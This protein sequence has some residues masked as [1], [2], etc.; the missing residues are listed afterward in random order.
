MTISGASKVNAGAGAPA[1]QSGIGKGS[2]PVSKEIQD[3]IARAQ[4]QLQELSANTELSAD[5]KMKKRQELQKQISDL[6]VQLRQHQVEQRKKEREEKASFDDMLGT[7]PKNGKASEKGQTAAVPSQ[8]NMEAMISAGTSMEQAK[9]HGSVATKMENRAEVLKA[10]IKLDSGRAGSSNIED[11]KA[12]V[13]ELEQKAME[14]T[15][16]QMSS[17]A[18]ANKTLEEASKEEQTKEEKDENDD[19][20]K[21]GENKKAPEG[22]EGAQEGEQTGAVAASGVEKASSG[23]QA[24]AEAGVPQIAPVVHYKPVDV[25]L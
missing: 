23:A 17:L 16:S 13:A 15:S 11:K 1:G 14:A 4:K 7:Q 19:E 3:K 2:D 22:A 25:R 12:E 24:Q 20:K 18:E 21:A 9:V 10:E 6:N 8:A 5:A